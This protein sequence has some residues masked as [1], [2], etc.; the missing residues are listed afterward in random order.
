MEER[1]APPE[2]NEERYVMGLVARGPNLNIVY[3]AV[4]QTQTLFQSFHSNFWAAGP[5]PFLTQTV[6]HSHRQVACTTSDPY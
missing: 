5:S 3:G 6:S 1:T 2:V 4:Q